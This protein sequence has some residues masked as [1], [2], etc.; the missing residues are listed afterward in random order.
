MSKQPKPEVVWQSKPD[1]AGVSYRIVVIQL[2]GGLDGDNPWYLPEKT[3]T[4]AMG[5]KIWVPWKD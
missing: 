5:K 1:R 3:G 4:D 2:H